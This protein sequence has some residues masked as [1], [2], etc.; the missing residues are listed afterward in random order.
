MRIPDTVRIG[1]GGTCV[2]QARLDAKARLH[3]LTIDEP[4][5][6]GGTDLGMSPLETLMASFAGCLNVVANMTAADMGIRLALDDIAVDA[7]F[8]TAAVTG[9]ARVDVPFSE[10]R[11]TFRGSAAC[12]VDVLERLQQDLTWRCPISAVFRA[13]GLPIVEDWQVALV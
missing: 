11:V 4:A 9:R 2:S 5:V 8:V 1:V 3:T 12:T 10:V 6:R 13:A 7:V